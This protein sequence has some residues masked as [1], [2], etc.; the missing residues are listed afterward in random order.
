MT[1]SQLQFYGRAVAYNEAAQASMALAITHNPYAETAHKAAKLG[2]TLRQQMNEAERGPRRSIAAMTKEQVEA[3]V[4]QL[5][6][7]FGRVKRV[8]LS[9]EELQAKLAGNGARKLAR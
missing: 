3:G 2:R 1:W 5:D 8:T 7:I 4:R 6:K 9:K